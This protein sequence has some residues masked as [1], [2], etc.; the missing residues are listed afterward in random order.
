MEVVDMMDRRKLDVLCVQETKWKGSKARE[1]GQGYK[2]YYNRSDSSRNGVGLIIKGGLSDSVMEVRRITDRIMVGR[3]EIDI[4]IINVISTYAAQKEDFWDKLDD[5]IETTQK[6]ERLI[7]GVDLNGHV[8]EGNS[9]VNTFFIK[10]VSHHLTYT[11]TGRQSQI[12]YTLHCRRNLWEVKDCKVVP[13]ECVSKQ[14]HV[15]TTK[16]KIQKRKEKASQNQNLRL[17]GGKLIT[18]LLHTGK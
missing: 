16:L 9:V 8:G 18:T 17:S 14:H 3:M 2:L 6:H 13:G 5:A 11:S 1:L 12:D 10:Q 4:I 7:V 15:V